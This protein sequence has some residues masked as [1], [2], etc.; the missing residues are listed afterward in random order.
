V[1][2]RRRFT[3][4][5]PERTTST[6]WIGAETPFIDNR[7]LGC[8]GSLLAVRAVGVPATINRVQA[9]WGGKWNN[10]VN[11]AGDWVGT[12]SSTD[13]TPAVLEN[14]TAWVRAFDTKNQETVPSNHR[15]EVHDLELICHL[16]KCGPSLHQRG[17]AARMTGR[18]TQARR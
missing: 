13:G 14:G 12:V 8:S 10:L 15:R 3:M 2:M 11:N 5:D 1:P 16:G 18:S 17:P 9:Y 4:S 6:V 7:Y